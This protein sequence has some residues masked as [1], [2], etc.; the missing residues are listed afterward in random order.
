MAFLSKRDPDM[1][2][3][4]LL[5][6]ILFISY[7]SVAISLPIVP[8]YVKGPLGF[9]NALAG[10]GVGVAFLSTIFTR[11]YAG[12]L[13][14]R[15]G[16]K[17][18]VVKGLI[19][20]VAGAIASLI[21]AFLLQVP[22]LAFVILVVGRLLIGLGESLVAVGV[23][24]WGIGIVGPSRS[25]RVLSMVGAAM[26]GALAVGGPIGLSLYDWLGFG[27]SLATGAMLPLI[28]L[29]CVWRIPGVAP[30]QSA[31]RPPL[32]KVVGR[33]WP[34]GLIVCSQGIGFAAIG[35]FFALFFR[36][37]AWGHA[38][39]GLTAF[40]CGFVLMRLLFGHLPDRIGGLNI[41]M[42]SLA[43]ELAGQIL[44][45]SS[46]TPGLALA[47]ALLTGIGCSLIFPAMGREVVHLVEPHLRGTALGGFSAFQDLAYGLTG[48]LV[49]LIAD[50]SGYSNVFLIGALA[51][52][53]GLTIAVIL[54]GRFPDPVCTKPE[55]STPN[56]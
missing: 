45:W 13:S 9:G 2:R 22:I 7:L 15:R 56:G 38:G 14:D 33:I 17:T 10:L 44:I 11:G 55:R 37:Q 54:R 3:L 27:L 8:L 36:D 26:Y 40:G 31:N 25:G 42:V 49:G 1:G 35:S 12:G 23:I 4:L 24:G 52:A 43:I 21:S 20:Y 47:G 18:A 48:P 32:W 53:T 28:G 41:A 46:Y 51:S 6:A 50:R 30:H 34:Y 5:A 39:L 29:I 16:A 19:Y